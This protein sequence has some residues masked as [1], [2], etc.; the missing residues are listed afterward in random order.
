M[1]SNAVARGLFDSVKAYIELDKK[2][3]EVKSTVVFDEKD[4][5]N[6]SKMYIVIMLRDSNAR[7]KDENGKWVKDDTWNFAYKTKKGCLSLRDF[8]HFRMVKWYKG[9]T[10]K[11]SLIFWSKEQSESQRLR[12]FANKFKVCTAIMESV[13]ECFEPATARYFETKKQIN[14]A[15]KSAQ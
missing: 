11:K 5:L 15:N 3:Y 4:P 9:E 2:K 1:N 12:Q 6:V 7:R 8:T 10:Y 13:S 14:E